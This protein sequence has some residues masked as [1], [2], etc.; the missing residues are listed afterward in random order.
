MWYHT[1]IR[2]AARVALIVLGVIFGAVILGGLSCYAQLNSWRDE[3][4]PQE[5][6]ASAQYLDNQNYLSSYVSGFY[7]QTSVVQASGEALRQILLDAVK[8]RYDEG[9]FAVNSPLFAAIVEAYPEAG[10]QELMVN[11]GRIQEY[12]ASG[13][14]GYREMQS[15]LLD[16][17]RTYDT[18]R[19]KG[20]IRSLW[21]ASVLG[22]PTRNL[23]A[24]I[25]TEVSYGDEAREQM[26]RIVLASD[27]RRAYETGEMEPL[28]VPARERTNP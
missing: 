9:G 26:Y 25:G 3:G 6:Q 12:I 14:T 1:S 22:F 27:A 23:E 8:G 15:K 10:V 7:E 16:Q 24:R 11:W 28:E 13:R 4:I 19:A 5:R 17:L 18:W 20:I 2:G 21:I